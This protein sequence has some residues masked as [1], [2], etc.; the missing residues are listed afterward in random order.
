MRRLHAA[1]CRG[2]RGA[3]ARAAGCRASRRAAARRPRAAFARAWAPLAYDGV[4]REL[5]AALKFRGAL[6]VARLMAAHMAANLP[7]DLRAR[8]RRA[9]GRPRAAAPPRRRR[10]AG[11]T[12]RARS[13]RALAARSAL[14]L[15]PCLRAA[16]PRAPAGRRAARAAPPRPAGSRSSCARPPPARALLVDDVH[17]TGATLDACARALR[18]RRLRRGGGADLR[19]DAVR[20]TGSDRSEGLLSRLLAPGGDLRRDARGEPVGAAARCARRSPARRG[21][22]LLDVGGGTGNYARALRD[23]GWDPLVV[24]RAPAMLARAA[25]QG[26]GD[27]SRRT[28]SRC[29]S[30]TRAPTPLMLVS[31]LHHVEDP[32]AALARGAPRCCARAG[33]SR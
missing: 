5:V 26:P 25:A 21:R 10:R 3:R 24:D 7:A 27:P 18:A 31:M 17:T 9:R 11:S 29:R 1:R 13:R 20:H 28:R 22:R 33:G 2:C 16:R 14:P 12:P 15:A 23:E 19:A 32:A 8:G 4:A 30:P 6:P